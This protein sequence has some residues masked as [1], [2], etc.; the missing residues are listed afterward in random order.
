MMVKKDVQ[1]D[2]DKVF[3]TTKCFSPMTNRYSGGFP[4]GFLKY[5]KENASCLSCKGGGR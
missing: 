3:R 5:L 2:K 4:I 1:W